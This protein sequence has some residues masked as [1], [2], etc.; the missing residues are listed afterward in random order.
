MD[1]IFVKYSGTDMVVHMAL[2][3]GFKVLNKLFKVLLFCIPHCLPSVFVRLISYNFSSWHLRR[4]TIAVWRYA[5]PRVPL[6]S[7]SGLGWNQL[8][9]LG[10]VG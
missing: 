9:N 6:G 7:D 3:A 10:L 5:A 1:S 8:L 4:D 2:A